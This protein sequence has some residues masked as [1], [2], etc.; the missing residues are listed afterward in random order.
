MVPINQT[1]GAKDTGGGHAN[2]PRPLSRRQPAK[3]IQFYLQK[4]QSRYPNT[5]TAFLL[6]IHTYGELYQDL[7]LRFCTS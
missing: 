6:A 7:S 2:A 4:K 1:S 5:G 3:T